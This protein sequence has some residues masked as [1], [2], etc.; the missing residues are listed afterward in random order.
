MTVCKPPTGQLFQNRLRIWQDPEPPTAHNNPD[1]HS[2]AC[3]GKDVTNKG[4]ITYQSLSQDACQQRQ[5]K[6]P[7]EF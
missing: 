3:Q 1:M 2:R 7:E 5:F 6:V 4:G